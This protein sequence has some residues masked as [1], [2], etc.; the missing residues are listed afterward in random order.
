MNEVKKQRNVILDLLRIIAIAEIFL[1]H[2]TLFIPEVVGDKVF[3]VM[4]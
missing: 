3:A 2:L 1:M 4:S